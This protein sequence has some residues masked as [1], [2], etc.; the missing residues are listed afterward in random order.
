M[1]VLIIGGQDRIS[2][3]V[4]VEEKHRVV[5]VERRPAIERLRQEL[6]PDVW[7]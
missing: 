6:P 1:F 7:W 3:R 2:G 5:M 4:A